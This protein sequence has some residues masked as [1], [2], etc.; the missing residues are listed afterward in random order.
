M[1]DNVGLST[2]RGSGTSGYVQRNLAHMR[3]RDYGAPYPPK[4]ADSLRHKQRQPDKEIL[5]HDRKR[6]VEVKVLD[7][8]DTLEDEGSR[9]RRGRAAMRRVTQEAPCGIGEQEEHPRR[10]RASTQAF[11]ESPGSRDGRCQDQRER[12]AQKRAEDKQGLRGRKSLETAGG[13]DEKCLGEG[14]EEG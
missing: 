6:E 2:P 9:G 11:Q 13:E 8:R 14:R 5:E 12:E 3:P 10:S 1:S 4:D 7:L